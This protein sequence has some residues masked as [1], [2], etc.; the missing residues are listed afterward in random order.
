VDVNDFGNV[1][2]GVVCRN[3]LFNH[4][5]LIKGEVIEKL[6]QVAITKSGFSSALV[7]RSEAEV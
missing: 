4:V 7:G 2:L 3:E 5:T 6:C 1:W